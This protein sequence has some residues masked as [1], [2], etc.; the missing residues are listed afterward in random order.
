M[1]SDD[2]V[3]EI[4]GLI[5]REVYTT[6]GRVVGD[7]DDIKRNL[8]EAGVK[9]L[10]VSNVNQ[11]VVGTISGPSG[12]FIPFRWVRSVGDIILVTDGLERVTEIDEG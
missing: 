2:P 4:T 5:G 3:D 10:A 9:A 8:H 1:S 7:V 11:D 12:V 6:N